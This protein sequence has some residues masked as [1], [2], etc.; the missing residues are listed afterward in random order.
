M[1]TKPTARDYLGI[2]VFW[3][4]I[5]FFWG[6]MLFVVVQA[7]VK[8]LVKAER[9]TLAH[10][11]A[12]GDKEAVPPPSPTVQA[13]AQEAQKQLESEVAGRMSWVLGL[14]AF[15]ATITQL[16]FGALSDN[17]RNRS[18]RRRP[19]IVGGTLLST[20]AIVGFPYAQSYLGFFLL[21]LFIQFAINVATGPYQALLPDLIPLDHHGTASA[22]MGLMQLVGRTGGMVAGALLL[23]R[24][25]GILVL[26]ITFLVLLNLFMLWTVVMTK[27]PPPLQEPSCGVLTSIQSMF[28]VEL[29]AYP[30]FVWVLVSRFVINTGI[31]TI[32]PFL[33]YYLI[34]TFGLSEHDAFGKQALIGLIV[35][36][37][38]MAATFPAG[39]ASDRF[40]KKLVVYVTC[41]ISIAGG[42][43]FALSGSVTYALISAAVFGFGYGA[44][45]AVDWALVCN[46]L[47]PGQP[48]KYMGV[49]G[50]A[51]CVPQIVA[52]IM[53]GAIAQWTITH[54]NSALGYRATML[55]ALVWFGLGTFFIRWVRERKAEPAAV[56]AGAPV[57]DS[58]GAQV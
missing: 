9:P 12:L 33:Q 26:S 58:A 29:K 52:P 16:L 21:F 24:S 45:Q 49:W 53:G 3:L 1:L 40:S 7:R 4:A 51:D 44:F 17:S 42:L 19:Y 55:S 38:G 25:D 56:T 57:A 13:A 8:D 35:N 11:I 22:Y 48:A 2:S 36:V 5:S 27:E 39:V 50:F 47:P 30:S 10:A 14:G 32:L 31:Y 41:A 37:T 28:S 15:V 6:A 46:V 43:A 20:V 23:Q 54:Y 34:N 18:G